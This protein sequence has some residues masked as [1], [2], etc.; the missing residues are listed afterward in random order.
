M[1][2]H[3]FVIV[4]ILGLLLASL[5]THAAAASTTTRSNSSSL[6][7]CDLPVQRL[8]PLS[9]VPKPGTGLIYDLIDYEVRNVS[10]GSSRI[11]LLQEPSVPRL[12]EPRRR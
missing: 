6:P 7:T 8:T 5:S 1:K 10:R 9:P 2:I 4:L 12:P 11:H 3:R